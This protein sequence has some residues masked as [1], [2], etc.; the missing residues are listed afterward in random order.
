M[1]VLGVV[2]AAGINDPGYRSR[3]HVS[4]MSLRFCKSARVSRTSA[5][6]AATSESYSSANA[7]TIS[8]NVRPSQR[9]RI[10]CA[11]SF[12]STMPSGKSKTLVPLAESVC[13]RTPFARRGWAASAISIGMVNGIE[14]GPEHTAFKGEPAHRFALELGCVAI[15]KRDRERLVRI[16]LRLRC[17]TPEIIKPTRIDPGIKFFEGCESCLH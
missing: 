14:H 5:A 6:S 9:A 8:F 1:P 2:R 13:N 4:S 10:S 15:L 3:D 7:H 12:N 11:V 17:A 16:A